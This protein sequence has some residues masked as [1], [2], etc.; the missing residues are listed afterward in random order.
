MKFHHILS[1][2]FLMTVAA[3]GA[4]TGGLAGDTCTTDDD[5]AAGLECH[6]HDGEMEC[7]AH[8]EEEED[9]TDDHT[10]E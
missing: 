8:E 9:H 7:E 5:C 1:F 2:A 10:D 6:D 4:A 3:C